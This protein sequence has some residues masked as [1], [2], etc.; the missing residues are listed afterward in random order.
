VLAVRLP[1]WVLGGGSA[2][3]FGCHWDL[4]LPVS[5]GFPSSSAAGLLL[6]VSNPEK[7]LVAGVLLACTRELHIR[8]SNGKNRRTSGDLDLSAKSLI[9]SYSLA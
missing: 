9:C 2:G 3:A 7:M 4:W 5:T 1:G 6:A 8:E